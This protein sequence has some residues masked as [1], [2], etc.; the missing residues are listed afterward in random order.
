MN[1]LVRDYIPDLI[2]A[3]GRIPEIEIIENDAEYEFAL[4]IKLMEEV[5]EFLESKNLEELAD[6]LEVIYA[7]SNLKGVNEEQLDEIRT[8]KCK[9]S[10]SFT[11]RILLKNL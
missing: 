1:K 9:K 8:E 2:I 10:G 7:I 5:S 4:T 11:N 3:D 6:I